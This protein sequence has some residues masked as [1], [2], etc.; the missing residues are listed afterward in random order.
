MKLLLPNYSYLLA[1]YADLRPKILLLALLL[2][3]GTTNPL[4]AGY[5]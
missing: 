4:S 3:L 5:V 1:G 2:T